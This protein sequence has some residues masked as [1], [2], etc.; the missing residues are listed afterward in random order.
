MLKKHLWILV[1]VP[2]LVFSG[3]AKPPEQE[4]S[5]ADEAMQAAMASQAE[6]Y[7]PT[8]DAMAKDAMSKAKAEVETQN[9]KFVLFRSYSE[10]KTLFAAAIDA[11]NKSKETAIVNKEAVKNEAMT[12]IAEA[13]TAVEGAGK[14]LRTAPRGK[15]SKAD[16]DAM[17]ADL[18]SLNAMLPELD[19]AM[20]GE[21][22]MDAKNKAMSVK[23]KAMQIQADVE[24][25]KAKRKK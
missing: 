22:F 11:S 5:Q 9:A 6:I 12:L 18:Q 7:A 25:A 1:L 19:S 13:K 15:G 3:C 8:E 2:A 23:E 10:A 20:A 21:M 16:L 24:A 17:S 4:I 14:A